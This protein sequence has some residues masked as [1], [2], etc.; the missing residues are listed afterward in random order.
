[1]KPGAERRE[2]R[3]HPVHPTDHVQMLLAANASRE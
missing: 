2:A 3:I 1:V